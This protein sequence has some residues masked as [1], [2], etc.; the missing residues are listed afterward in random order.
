ML[1]FENMISEIV[2]YCLYNFYCLKHLLFKKQLIVDMLVYDEV[3]KKK[4]F[5]LSYIAWNFMVKII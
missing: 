1:M 2:F 5:S 4:H 3:R